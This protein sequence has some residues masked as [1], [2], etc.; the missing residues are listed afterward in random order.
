MTGS[1]NIDSHN[2]SPCPADYQA[3]LSSPHPSSYPP[4]FFAQLPVTDSHPAASS[5]TP[6]TKPPSPPVPP[7]TRTT[8]PS[9]TPILLT[10]CS[11]TFTGTYRASNL[12]R[13]QRTLHE[14]E[15]VK[16]LY[17]GCEK[18]F[19]RSDNM[20]VHMES[21]HR[22]GV[23]ALVSEVERERVRVR[24]RRGRVEKRRMGGEGRRERGAGVK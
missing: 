1:E 22:D 3:P 23:L 9:S 17:A 8:R 16:C 20:A 13:H 11:A 21:A 18:R 2:P 4:S 24:V 15:K 12:R 14:R 19:P 10:C 7:P 5:T 6:R